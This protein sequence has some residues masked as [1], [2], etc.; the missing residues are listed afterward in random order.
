VSDK[1]LTLK[2]VGAQVTGTSSDGSAPLSG[3]VY[4]CSKLADAASQQAGMIALAV[5]P[6]NDAQDNGMMEFLPLKKAGM[7]VMTMGET[8]QTPSISNFTTAVIC[9]QN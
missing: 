7:Y 3:Q 5:V 4:D 6:S 2:F 9:T 8:G 1:A